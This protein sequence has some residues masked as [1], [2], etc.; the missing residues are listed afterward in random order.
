MLTG[1]QILQHGCNIVGS[2]GDEK[3]CELIQGLALLAAM[4]CFPVSRRMIEYRQAS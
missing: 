4:G 2:I 3:F 1:L